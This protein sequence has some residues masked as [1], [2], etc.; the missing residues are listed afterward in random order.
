M[1]SRKMPMICVQW[2]RILFILLSFLANLAHATTSDVYEPPSLF[3][4][5]ITS[6]VSVE[7]PRTELHGW[8]TA[9]LSVL[10][11][12]LGFAYSALISTCKEWTF[13]RQD[14]L[15]LM[16]LMA[17]LSW[18]VLTATTDVPSDGKSASIST[19]FALFAVFIAKHRR[20]LRNGNQYLFAC[21][22]GGLTL[23]TT[24]AGI[25]I[26]MSEDVSSTDLP[27]MRTFV[28]LAV[29]FGPTVTSIWSWVI[30]LV[31]Q[32][33][34]KQ[35]RSSRSVRQDAVELTHLTVESTAGENGV[36]LVQ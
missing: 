5:K 16:S 8:V 11:A 17:A 21:L 20:V 13:K 30:M 31:F 33:L 6:R 7:D 10:V 32:I 26:L 27:S 22:L 3:D 15:G 25:A 24:A 34:E 1:A 36:G 29:V 18:W 19:W 28:M 4:D 12:C 23:T 9:I 14:F 2:T 35:S